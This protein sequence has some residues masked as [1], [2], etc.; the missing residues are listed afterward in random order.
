MAVTVHNGKEQITSM[1]RHMVPLACVR[2]AR[3][4]VLRGPPDAAPRASTASPMSAG[5]CAIFALCVFLGHY[6]NS[7]AQAA[8]VRRGGGRDW[9]PSQKMRRFWQSFD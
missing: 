4:G 5:H 2:A 8:R 6:L 3:A 9:N 7:A 1:A